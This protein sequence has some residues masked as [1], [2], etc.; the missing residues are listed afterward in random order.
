[1]NPAARGLRPLPLFLRHVVAAS[2]VDGEVANVI[3][4]IMP[5]LVRVLRKI[6]IRPATFAP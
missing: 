5:R 4:R 6:P 1:M 2:L 3:M